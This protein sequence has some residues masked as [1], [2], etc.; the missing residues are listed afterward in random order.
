MILSSITD[1]AIYNFLISSQKLPKDIVRF[2]LLLSL[3]YCLYKGFKWAK[4]I[5]SILCIVGGL[6]YIAS[7]LSY[8]V[9]EEELN[10]MIGIFLLSFGI[11]FTLSGILILSSKNI[12]LFLIYQQER[13][14]RANGLNQNVSSMEQKITDLVNSEFGEKYDF[15]LNLRKI[16]EI[17]VNDYGELQELMISG[18]AVLR[19]Y[20]LST[21][22]S[23]FNIIATPAESTLFTIFSALTIIVPLAGLICS[24]VFSWWF[25]LFLLFPILSIRF[26][27]R[28]YLHA[29]FNRS[30]NSEKAFC[31]L[32]CGQFITLELAGHGIITR[33]V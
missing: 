15:I 23:T 4:W 3:I 10:Q 32:F 22:S 33:D 8:I 29:L 7:G 1:D 24:F 17:P 26:S 5:L 25:V 12:K 13:R 18:E 6:G 2:I 11:I 28:I 20:P 31:F 9:N 16:E 30:A 14:K 19:Q 21:A 27:K